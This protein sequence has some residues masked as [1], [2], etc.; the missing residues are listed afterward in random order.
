MGIQQAADKWVLV[1]GGSRGIGRS[2]VLALAKEGYRVAF[3]FQSSA[4]ATIELEREVAEAGGDVRGYVCDGRD[5]DSVE[6]ICT[7]LIADLG[8]LMR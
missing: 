4:D 5:Y 2:L 7:Q 3:T 1:T 8:S 6:R